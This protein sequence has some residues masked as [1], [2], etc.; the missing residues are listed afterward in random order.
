MEEAGISSRKTIRTALKRLEGR[1]LIEW[2]GTTKRCDRAEDAPSRH[3]RTF[4]WLLRTSHLTGSDLTAAA[5]D[6]RTS[7][8]ALR[9]DAFLNRSGLGKNAHRI[10]VAV[11]AAPGST[12]QELSRGLQIG[13]RTV[14]KHL[15]E[16]RRV[17]LAEED[18]GRWFWMSR[19]LDAVAA[20]LG[21]LGRMK[22]L[23][24]THAR[25]RRGYDEAHDATT[26]DG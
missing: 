5:E 1:G 2:M 25:Q 13:R 15:A 20:D 9:H 16:L 10:W 12:P 22:G 6:R 23:R 14:H 7:V 17:G 3:H 19:D 21:N 26:T 18:G 24:A 11:E 8:S 4:R